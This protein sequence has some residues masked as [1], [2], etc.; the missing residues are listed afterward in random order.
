MV[1]NP[2]KS[3]EYKIDEDEIAKAQQ[4]MEKEEGVK[5]EMGNKAINMSQTQV[6]DEKIQQE[7]G[8]KAVETTVEIDEEEEI[9]M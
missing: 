3:Y 5:R 2:E 4:R 8:E 7:L 1:Y 9:S 6:K